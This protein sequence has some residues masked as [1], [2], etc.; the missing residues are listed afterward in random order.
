MTSATVPNV[1]QVDV[2]R[3]R[4]R[5]GRGS[6]MID[7]RASGGLCVEYDTM[8][9][10]H[11]NSVVVLNEKRIRPREWCAKCNAYVCDDKKCATECYSMQRCLDLVAANPEIPALPRTK[12][13]GLLFDPQLLE[14][15]RPF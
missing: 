4:V 11:C 7:N 2:F 14:Q 5:G 15:G 8:T 10:A 6:I 9:C 13:G 12:D 3:N 1:R